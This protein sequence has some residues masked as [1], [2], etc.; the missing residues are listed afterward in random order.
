MMMGLDCNMPPHTQI[1]SYSVSSGFGL[2]V[3]E[4]EDSGK[5]GSEGD[6]KSQQV[7]AAQACFDLTPL[8]S[9]IAFFNGLIRSRTR[10]HV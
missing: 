9:Q 1:M 5:K 10:F 6:N 4:S 8:F 3:N 7:A 2:G